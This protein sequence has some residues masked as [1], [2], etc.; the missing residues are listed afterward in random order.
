MNRYR[1]WGWK[2][3]V[4]L[5]QLGTGLIVLSHN[6]YLSSCEGY[7]QKTW[8]IIVIIL[9][10]IFCIN[11]FVI[12]MISYF[13][14]I[15]IS[16]FIVIYIY[17]KNKYR[18]IER[19]YWKNNKIYFWIYTLCYFTIYISLLYNCKSLIFLLMQ[20]KFK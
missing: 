14:I 11:M 13:F 16:L 6:I 17:K 15:I 1:G 10:G 18:K 3:V 7:E 20:K 8:S 2:I 19:Y 9:L 12:N 4:H 5:C